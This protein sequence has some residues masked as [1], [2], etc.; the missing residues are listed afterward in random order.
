MDTPDFFL[1]EY[2]AAIDD[3]TRAIQITPDSVD[4]YRNRAA[5]HLNLG[6]KQKAIKDYQ[7]AA[8]LYKKQGEKNKLKKILEK[9]Q[10]LE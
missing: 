1:K 3:Y 9:L 5:V 6:N 4:A 2:Q 8:T 7:K 10:N